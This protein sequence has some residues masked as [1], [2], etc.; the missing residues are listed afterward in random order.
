[1]ALLGSVLIKITS[2][3]KLLVNFLFFDKDGG[4]I[5]LFIAIYQVFLY[6]NLRMTPAQCLPTRTTVI[7]AMVLMITVR[8]I[9][10]ATSQVC[11]FS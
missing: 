3:K 11:R 8:A 7:G 5:C 6:T 4:T 2:E 1:M 10:T 9:M